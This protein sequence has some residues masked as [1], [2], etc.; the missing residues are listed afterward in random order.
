MWLFTEHGLYSVVC[1]RQGDGP[2]NRP[3]GTARVMV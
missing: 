3:T 1:A 2:H